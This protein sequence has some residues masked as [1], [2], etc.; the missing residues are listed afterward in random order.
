MKDYSRFTA[1]VVATGLS[2]FILSFSVLAHAQISPGQNAMSQLTPPAKASASPVE[3]PSASPA[4]S[5]V[6]SATVTPEEKKTLSK[7]FKRALSNEE[8]ALSHRE[9]SEMKQLSAAQATKLKNWREGERGTR[10]KYFDQHMS[11]PERRDYVQGYLKRKEAFDQS[12]LDELAQAKKDW[13]VRHEE[14]TKS[15]KEREAIFQKSLDQD[16]RPAASLWPK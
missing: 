16:Y 10:R 5:P 2:V 14:L 4:A 1:T 6:L 7:E 13:K 12:Q 9:R 15:Q 8:K 11:G 3:S